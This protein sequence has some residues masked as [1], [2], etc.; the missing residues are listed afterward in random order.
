MQVEEYY[1]ELRQCGYN[2]A[3]NYSQRARNI[4]EILLNGA[5]VLAPTANLKDP[6]DE[7]MEKFIDNFHYILNW[8][9]KGKGKKYYL[10]LTEE[11]MAEIENNLATNL[12][13]IACLTAMLLTEDRCEE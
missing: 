8:A 6:P 3:E 13:T 11:E 4:I 12:E 5:K 9:L 7:L 1:K 2:V 10:P